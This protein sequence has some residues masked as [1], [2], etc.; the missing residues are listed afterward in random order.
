[1]SDLKRINQ[2]LG[3]TIVVNL[4]SV[5]LAREYGTRIIGLRDGC[6]VF[7]GPVSEATD[8]KL[9]EIYGNEI[10]EEQGGTE[11]MTTQLLPK[12]SGTMEEYS[13]V[14]AFL[15][16]LILSG[17]ITGVDLRRFFENADQ[18]NVILIKMLRPDWSYS[19][20]IVEPLLQT[21]QMAIV[22]TTF[23]GA[24]CFAFFFAGSQKYPNNSLAIGDFSL[25]FEYRAN[26]S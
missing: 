7:D 12:R 1:M 3:I 15:L 10:I 21:I 16:V 8:R 25:S 19:T 6:L 18:M 11:K 24:H 13:L 20:I 2:E 14:G 5:Q 17:S 23:W 22:G 9:K 26:D 4:H